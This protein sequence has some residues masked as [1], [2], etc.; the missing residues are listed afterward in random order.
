MRKFDFKNRVN[1]ISNTPTNR[2]QNLSLSAS[3]YGVAISTLLAVVAIILTVKYG[4]NTEALEQLKKTNLNLN[5]Q[6]KLLNEELRIVNNN[7]TA[8]RLADSNKFS[9][10]VAEL[11]NIYDSSYTSDKDGIPI[12]KNEQKEK[13]ALASMKATIE[14]Q[15]TNSFLLQR[16]D[17]LLIKWMQLD[18]K[19]ISAFKLYNLVSK[20]NE[21]E[22]STIGPGIFIK[23]DNERKEESIEMLN[24]R[25]NFVSLLKYVRSNGLINWSLI[26]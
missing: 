19:V 24:V 4:E 6:T 10:S 23:D 8:Q 20:G 25:E 26:K 13:L 9:V 7:A 15:L 5:I 17:S 16:K 14:S 18:N 3:I 2:L 22:R 11:K 21:A 12:K 1:W